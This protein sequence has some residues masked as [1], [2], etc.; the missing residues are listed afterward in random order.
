MEEMNLSLSLSLRV[1]QIQIFF[2]EA[3][4]WKILQGISDQVSHG[5]LVN[6]QAKKTIFR[7]QYLH[8]SPYIKSEYNR[9]NGKT[10]Y[11]NLCL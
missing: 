3:F 6:K 8:F 11:W 10:N 9:V 2:L 5:W 4:P 7:L 1:E